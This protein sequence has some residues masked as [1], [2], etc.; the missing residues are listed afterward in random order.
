M[1][2]KRGS[3]AV[4]ILWGCTALGWAIILGIDIFNGKA[5]LYMILLH[6]ACLL[7]FGIAAAMQFIRYLTEKSRSDDDKDPLLAEA[8]RIFERDPDVEVSFAF[9]GAGKGAFSY[10]YR[11]VHQV[12]ENTLTSG[13]HYYYDVKE[14]PPDGKAEGTITFLTPEAY[15]Y[16]LYAGKVIPIIEGTVTVGEA[17]VKRVLNPI[18]D[19]ASKK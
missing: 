2:K 9:N 4:P 17:T 11:P 5:D 3:L 1:S 6:V 8:L 12:T 10:G 15:P 14:V 7:V 18:L 13:V 19:E 16:C